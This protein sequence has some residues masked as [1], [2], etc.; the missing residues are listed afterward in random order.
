MQELAA[1]RLFAKK[2]TLWD[3][4]IRIARGAFS[5]LALMIAAFLGGMVAG[6]YLPNYVLNKKVAELQTEKEKLC[7]ELYGPESTVVHGMCA[8]KN[9][10]VV[11]K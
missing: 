4:F 7:K 3:R 1:R 11:R 9:G 5:V 8:M 2:Q 10:K 6:L